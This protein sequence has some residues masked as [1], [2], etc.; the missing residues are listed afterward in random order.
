MIKRTKWVERSFDF[1]FPIGVFP[2]IIERLRGTPVR[3]EEIAHSLDP[4]LLTL[5]TDN[6]WSIQEH[7]GHL[8][9]LDLLHDGRIDDFL[10][11]AKVLRA[12]DMSN[13]RTNEENYNLLLIENI[14]NKFRTGREKLVERLE[15]MDESIVSRIALHP[16]L[17]KPMRLADM[18]YFTAEHDDHHL[19]MIRNLLFLQK[20]R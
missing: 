2:C 9:D 15:N 8:A 16:R 18:A 4:E 13:K 10:A 19:S 1:N 12:A 14:L 20:K 5:R 11:G 3:L 7:M 6:A 17:N